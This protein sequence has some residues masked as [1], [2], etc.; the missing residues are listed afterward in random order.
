L[1]NEK[2][3]I[4]INVPFMPEVWSEVFPGTSLGQ[5]MPGREYRIKNLFPM[6]KDFLCCRVP[7]PTAN[8][9]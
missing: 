7:L 4:L 6:A 5:E 3:D 8:F 2:N 9:F 1:L